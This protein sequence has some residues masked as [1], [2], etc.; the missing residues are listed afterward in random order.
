MTLALA[1]QGIAGHVPIVSPTELSELFRSGCEDAGASSYL[2]VDMMPAAERLSPRIVT[3]NFTYDAIQ[4]VGLEAVF[5]LA[6][7][8]IG[9]SPGEMPRGWHPAALGAL[10]DCP[11]L[12]GLAALG[13][14]ELFVLRLRTAAHRCVAVCAGRQSGTVDARA[15]MRLQMRACYALSCMDAALAA[16]D[17]PLSE[18]ERECLG[19]VAQGK[20]TD[21]VALIL[22][23]SSNTVNSYIAHAIH[24]LGASNR[25]MAIA[26]AIR[27][28]II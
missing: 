2:V 11:P 6:E 19:W 22:E 28:G 13:S 27:R 17:N 1:E 26:T 20:T 5:L 23:V 9:S 7:S 3:S 18:R 12:A 21:D 25:A 4:S 15:L 16:H 24:K 10:L 8:A 14:E